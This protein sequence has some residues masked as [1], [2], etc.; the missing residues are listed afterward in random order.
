M[1]AFAIQIFKDYCLLWGVLF[2]CVLETQK[3]L[4]EGDSCSTVE[5]SGL[6]KYLSKDTTK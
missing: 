6:F 1:A 5:E 2:F 3:K 4:R